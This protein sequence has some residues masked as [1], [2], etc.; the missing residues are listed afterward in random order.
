MTLDKAWEGRI[1]E[2]DGDAGRRL[3]QAVQDADNAKEP[4]IMLIGFACDEG[5]SRNKGRVGAYAGPDKIRKALANLPWQEHMPVYDYGNICCDDHDLAKAQKQLADTISEAMRQKHTPIILGGG[6]EVAWGSFQGLANHY[7]QKNCG[8]PSIGVINF[9]AH[10][11]LRTPY[12]ES[13]HGSSGTPFSQIAEFCKSRQWPFHYAC[14]GV[15]RSSNT[16]ALFNR[17]SALSVLAIEDVEMI[18]E[19]RTVVRDKLRSFINQVDVIYLTIDLDVL[20]ASAAPGV[21]APAAH[22]VDY[23]TIE[24]LVRDILKARCEDGTHKLRIA[25]IAELNPRFDIDDQTARIAARLVWTLMEKAEHL[26][27]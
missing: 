10:F 3:H 19:G 13:L 23:P 16:Q 11:D 17:A 25:D 27:K 2:E 5:V 8:T 1:D 22:G 14:L 7:I 21:S 20:P 15:S 4:G 26:A 6:H 9:D 12:N 24:W 18:T